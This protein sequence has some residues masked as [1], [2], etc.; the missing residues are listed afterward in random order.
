MQNQIGWRELNEVKTS[1]RENL[2]MVGGV[3]GTF[4]AIDVFCFMAW[5]A[6]GQVPMDNFY[7]GSITAHLIKLF[8]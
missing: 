3:I 4:L 8:I 7:L 5:V 2:E 1:F 6:S